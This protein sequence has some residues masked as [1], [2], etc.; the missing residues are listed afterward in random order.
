MSAARQAKTHLPMLALLLL[1]A[2]CT[3]P[4]SD[5]ATASAVEARYLQ[6]CAVCHD[7]GVQ[8]APVPGVIEDWGFRLEYGREDLYTNTILGVGEMPPRGACADC[9]DAE[10]RAIVDYMLEALA[11]D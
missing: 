7:Q 6:T 2:A 11:G 8:G 5:S 9:T 4:G 1:P 3:S 10:L